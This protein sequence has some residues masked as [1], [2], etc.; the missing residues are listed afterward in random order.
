[1]IFTSHGNAGPLVITFGL[2][3]LLG[4]STV[5]RADCIDGSPL[6]AGH[7]GTGDST[8]DN[9]YPENTIPSFIAAGEEGASMVELDVQLSADGIPVLMHDARVDLTTDGMGCVTELTL[10]ELQMLDA[11]VGSPM[12][13]TGI[14]IPTLEE[15]LE[16]IDLDLNVEIKNGGDGCAMFSDEEVATA[17]LDVL[18][19]D[20][21]PRLQTLS[22]FEVGILETVREQ[23][24]EIYIGFITVTVATVMVAVDADFDALNLIDGGVDE[25]AVMAAHD[26][27]LELNVWTVNDTARIEALFA[28]EVDSIITDEPPLVEMVRQQLCGGEDDTGGST[29]E[30]GGTEGDEADESGAPG[31]TIAESGSGGEGSTGSGA[32]LGDEDDSG[33]ACQATSRSHAPGGLAFFGLLLWGV[34]RRRR[35]ED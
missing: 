18:A 27:G 23:D 29:G 33:C 15:V 31:G 25:A 22:S 10:D 28:M 11:G 5:A 8:A 1:V 30:P 9:P 21:S 14:T 17:V 20:P 3:A 4:A 13:G 26:A 6:N 7:R 16:G 32:A 24:A 12:E 19:A 2:A 35:G 34:G